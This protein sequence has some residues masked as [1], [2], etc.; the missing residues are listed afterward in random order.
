MSFYFFFVIALYEANHH[1]RLENEQ[2]PLP[3][4]HYSVSYFRWLHDI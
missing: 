2:L 3:E 1:H 4:S